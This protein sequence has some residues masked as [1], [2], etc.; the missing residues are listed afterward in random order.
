MFIFKYILRVKDYISFAYNSFLSICYRNSFG[1]CGRDVLIKP[2]T[3]IFKGLRNIYISDHVRIARYATI[4][5]TNAKVTIGPKVGIAPYLKIITGNHRTDVVGHYMFDGDYEK[6]PENDRDVLIEGDNWIGINVT[7]LSGV[8]I[9]RGCVIASGAIVTKSFPPYSIIGGVPAKILKWRFSIDE[10]I[11]HEMKLY[12]SEMR[13]TRLQ[14]ETMRN[15]TQNSHIQNF[16]DTLSQRNGMGGGN[17]LIS[18][19]L[20]ISYNAA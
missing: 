8:N 10:I 12:P 14:L 15:N 1:A 18:N 2:S 13:F 3:S 7:I 16:T 6:R 11:S 4:Y 19:V 20:D 5:S 9:G 17:Y